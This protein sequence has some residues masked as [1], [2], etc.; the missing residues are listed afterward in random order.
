MKI[1]AYPMLEMQRGIAY[2]CELYLE[3]EVYISQAIIKLNY[4]NL[5]NYKKAWQ[6]VVNKYEIFKTKFVFGDLKDDVQIVL[7]EGELIWKEENWLQ[8]ELKEK[9]EKEKVLQ[10]A[11]IL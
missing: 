7:N 1:A 8:I 10:L 9:A 11:S 3:N 4:D 5:T 2:E 6:H